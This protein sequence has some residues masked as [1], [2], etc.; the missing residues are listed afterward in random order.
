M[1]ELGL[2]DKDAWL[3]LTNLLGNFPSQPVG[4]S[5][6]VENDL[7]SAIFLCQCWLGV[8]LAK[9][10]PSRNPREDADRPTSSNR[11]CNIG[12]HPNDKFSTLPGSRP[13]PRWSL[14]YGMTR[15]PHT[16]STHIIPI[17]SAANQKIKGKRGN[18]YRHRYRSGRWAT[19]ALKLCGLPGMWDAGKAQHGGTL[20]RSPIAWFRG[21][22]EC[23]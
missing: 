23:V 4:L 5:N 8:C 17:S 16:G 15:G 1:D 21:A 18:Y 19:V 22:N 12:G 10:P 11:K 13:R 9:L 20:L 2:A 6:G 7:L 3:S 14:P